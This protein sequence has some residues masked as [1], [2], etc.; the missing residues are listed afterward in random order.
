MLHLMPFLRSVGS[1]VEFL[2]IRI[3]AEVAERSEVIGGNVALSR[4]SLS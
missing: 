3:A 2:S 1:Q 4:S